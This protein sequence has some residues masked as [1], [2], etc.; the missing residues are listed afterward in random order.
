MRDID[1]I[2]V[3]CS[4]TPAS[5]DIGADTI[6]Q[7]HTGPRF[8]PKRGQWRFQGEWWLARPEPAKGLPDG[9]GWSDI[10]YHYVILRDGTVEFGR[11]LERSGA[12]VAGHN[13]TS[14]GICL[15][16]GAGG[17]FDFTF[18]QIATL[19]ERIFKLKQVYPGAEVLGH[20]DLDG[21]KECPSLS[22]SALFANV[23]WHLVGA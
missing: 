6:R 5:M 18:E 12:H 9:N 10:G 17:S 4:D 3:H 19:R 23:D 16:G 20:R 7:W 21:S 14:V 2:V 11:P 15:V 13:A 1:K 22:V 8:D